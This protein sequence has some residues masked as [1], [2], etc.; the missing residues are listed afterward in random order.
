MRK[1]AQAA[2][3]GLGYYEANTTTRLTLCTTQ[4]PPLFL[5]YDRPGNKAGHRLHS[6]NGGAWPEQASEC[7]IHQVF[8]RE[9]TSKTSTSNVWT[10]YNK[11]RLT[12]VSQ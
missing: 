7:S 10:F 8:M 9:F 12:A 2:M 1:V 3:S 6:P 11:I 4:S 5:Q